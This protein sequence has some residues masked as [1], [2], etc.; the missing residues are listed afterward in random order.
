MRPE[1]SE[2]AND[3]LRRVTEFRDQHIIPNEKTFEEQVASGATR[4]KTVPIVEQLRA[5]AKNCG[6]WNLS[7]ADKSVG[8]GLTNLEYAPI[9]E[10]MG[11]NEWMPEVFNCNPPDSGNIGTLLDHGTDEQKERWLAPLLAGDIRSCFAMTEPDVASSDAR[12]IS[13]RCDR[14]GDGWALNG[15]KWWI[16]G[17]G[18][19][20]CRIAIVMCRTNSDG[21]TSRQHSMILVP[22]DTEGLTVTRQLNVF[23]FDFAPR[24]FSQLSF[25]NVRVPINNILGEEGGGF[26]IAQGR[27]GPGRLHHAMRCIGAAERALRLMCKRGMSRIAFGKEVLKLGGNGEIIARCRIDIDL[28][29]E[30]VLTTAHILD[31]VGSA[32]ARGRLSQ[33]KV[34]AP[35]MACRVIDQAMQMHGA[36]GFSQDTPLSILYARIRA[37]RVADGP[38]AVHLRVISK[39]ELQAI[40]ELR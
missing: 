13:L 1:P 7:L 12:N 38:D 33:A 23:G 25:K 11:Y 19:P 27:L 24:G 10:V 3:L 4:W 29:R 26:T 14:Q 32:A 17:P 15:D 8:P 16:S 36:A 2:L 28:V 39:T 6:L 21:D 9:A 34:A 22:I 35:A 40:G 30:F 5:E 31:T 20:M 37:I 18:N